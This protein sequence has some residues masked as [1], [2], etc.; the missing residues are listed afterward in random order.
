MARDAEMKNT[1]F[2]IF[3]SGECPCGGAFSLTTHNEQEEIT[4]YKH[5]ELCLMSASESR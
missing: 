4:H 2:D 1:L 3:T 5:L